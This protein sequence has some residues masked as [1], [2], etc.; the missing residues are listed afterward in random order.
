MKEALRQ[1][2]PGNSHSSNS[3]TSSNTDDDDDDDGSDSIC[4]ENK[5]TCFVSFVERVCQGII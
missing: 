1:L 2:T 5:D 4:N 3:S